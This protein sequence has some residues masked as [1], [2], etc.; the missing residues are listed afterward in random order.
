[1]ELTAEEVGLTNRIAALNGQIN[2]TLRQLADS[3]TNNAYLEKQLQQLIEAKAELEHKFNTLADVRAQV[4]KLRDDLYTARRLEWMKEG[5]DV[6]IKGAQLLV[7]LRDRNMA[8]A[9]PDTNYGLRVEIGSDG[10]V[11]AL[12][13][14]TNAAPAT[15]LP[16]R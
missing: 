11:R 1:L 9:A 16:A 12:P 10:S 2:D 7:R 8:P 5:T 14:N 13:L 4:K 3:K 6:P 15:N